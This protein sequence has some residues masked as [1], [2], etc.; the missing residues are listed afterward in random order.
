MKIKQ[1]AFRANALS[2]FAHSSAALACARSDN[3]SLYFLAAEP[4]HWI[5]NGWSQSFGL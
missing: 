5:L 1:K 4:G 3:Q 2:F